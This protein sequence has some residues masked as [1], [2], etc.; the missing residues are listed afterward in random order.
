MADSPDV[1]VFSKIVNSRRAVRSFRSDEVPRDDVK[2]ILEL[3]Q[4]GFAF[5]VC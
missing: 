5:I 4:V 2:K 1:Q 3:T